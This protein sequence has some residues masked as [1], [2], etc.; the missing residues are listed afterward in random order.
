VKAGAGMSA[1]DMAISY[2][3]TLHLAEHL[4]TR[5]SPFPWPF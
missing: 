2:A 3:A 5:I 4:S 1:A